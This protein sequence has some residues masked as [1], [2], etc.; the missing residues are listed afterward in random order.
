MTIM[1]FVTKVLHK[2]L[3]LR[4]S[5]T[6]VSC[7]IIHYKIFVS[8]QSTLVVYCLIGS[9]LVTYNGNNLKANDVFVALIFPAKKLEYNTIFSL[10]LFY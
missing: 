10:G 3:L 5:V 4:S 6:F 8:I 9:I 7:M 2:N 1:S